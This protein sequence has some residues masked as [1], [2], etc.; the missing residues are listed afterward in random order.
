[1][2]VGRLKDET[3][4]V[5]VRAGRRGSLLLVLLLELEERGSRQVA[6]VVVVGLL[7]TVV[8]LGEKFVMLV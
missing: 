4:W 3:G 6:V 7:E 8:L 5:V 2:S 1:V